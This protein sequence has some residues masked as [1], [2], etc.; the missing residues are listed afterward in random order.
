[1]IVICSK[2]ILL[3]C[4]ASGCLFLEAGQNAASHNCRISGKQIPRT[5]AAYAGFASNLPGGQA[6]LGTHVIGGLPARMSTNSCPHLSPTDYPAMFPQHLS[7]RVGPCT[8]SRCHATSRSSSCGFFAGVVNGV[9][10]VASVIH[11]CAWDIWRCHEIIRSSA[12]G[13]WAERVP[14]GPGAGG[15]MG[16]FIHRAPSV[17]QRWDCLP[18]RDTLHRNTKEGLGY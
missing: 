10:G 16:S 17:T 8:G 6:R 12:P 18:V 13:R 7:W 2:S 11:S 15:M 4:A 3:C 14:S 9:F 1:M 5:A